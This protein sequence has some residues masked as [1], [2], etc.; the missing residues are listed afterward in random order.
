MSVAGSYTASELQ[1]ASPRVRG[2]KE[3]AVMTASH[4]TS[5][6]AGDNPRP[7]ACPVRGR[8]AEL[9]V[10]GSLVAEL[11]QGRGGVLVIE[12][13]PGIGKSRLL[14]ESRSLAHRAGIRT[15]FGQAFEYQQAVPF[16]SLFTAT[17]Y[18]DP[19]VGDEE[20]LRRL[21]SSADLRYWVVHDLNRAIRAAAGVTPLV[22]LLEDIHWADTSTLLA[23]RTLTA[24]PHVSPVLWVLTART[25]AGGPPVRDTVSELERQ[26]AMYLRLSAMSRSGV[27][28]MIEDAVRARADVS[29]LNL[30]DKAHGNPF[31]VT[32]LLGGLNEES[33]LCISR[34]CA[35]AAG[36]TLPRRLSVNMGQRLDALSNATT[37]VVQ[38]AAVLPDLFTVALLAQML[39][40]RPAAL[41][42][43]VEEAV[44]ADLL[45]EDGDHLRFR[46]DL[47]REATRQSLPPSLRRAVER[48]AATVMLEMGAAPAEVATQLARSADVGDQAA[49]TALREAAQ[50][51]AN[52]D[53]SGAA[54]LSK[55]AL[56]LLP[57][58]DTQ[59]GA[60]LAETVGLLN[61]SGRYQEAEEL[62]VAMLAQL[63]PEE[64]AQTR[65][66]TPN[67]ADALEK[68]IA[69]NRRALQL[70][71]I[72]DVTRARHL[73]WLACNDAVSGL[74]LDVSVI[75][76]ARAAAAVTGDPESGAICEISLAITDYVDGYA[77][78]GLTRLEKLDIRADGD[79]PSFT[80]AL[81]SIHQTTVLNFVGRA[82]EATDLM[83][84]GVEVSRR[85]GSEV[86][87]VLWASQGA[88]I[89]LA[90][91]RLSAA[92]VTL[93]AV[94]PRLWGAMSE[95]GMQRWL[96]LA[97]VAVRT[98]D[99]KLLQDIV[100]EARAANPAGLNLVQRGAAY[101]VALT[102]WDCGD[103]H[104][105]V[106]WMSCDTGQVLNP[107]WANSFDQLILT[108]RVA[109]AAGDAGLRA[110]ALRGVELLEHDSNEVPLFSAVSRH[111]LGIL[112]RDAAALVDA[113]AALRISRPLLSACAAEDAGAALAQTGSNAGAVDQFNY[114][115]DTYVELEA[116]ADARRVAGRLRCLGVVRRI[117][118]HPREKTG[119]DSLTAAELKVVNLIADGAT[120]PIV[121]ERLRLSPHTVK[122]HV[123]NAFAKLG[124]SCRAQLPGMVASLGTR[125]ENNP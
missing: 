85:E 15:L 3:C 12:G 100:V 77:L 115:F 40:R 98:G 5:P 31:L 44:R 56:D 7:I 39:E 72:S 68:R 82:Q 16:F 14:A 124:I 117:S 118:T 43:A 26:G 57:A 47:L 36:E 78:R 105:A 111:T 46:H 88:M 19:P 123:R 55:R 1:P 109:A 114:A 18:A 52:S 95:M 41:V 106:R 70:S 75:T 17:I 101:V 54:D 64:E 65:L 30:A 33:R 58:E 112:G 73:A 9:K 42:S 96:V 104:E 71:Q 53:K 110:R 84:R 103:V 45:V 80:S 37:E 91:G 6:S 69:E 102:A 29:L 92:R 125:S 79:D 51:M 4:Y 119:W 38:I 32:E 122:S 2:A 108:A 11:T 25:G 99:R 49:V 61:Q 121:A 28:D 83:A 59:R 8:A 21:G 81:A 27:I 50:S 87:S 74:P 60:L 35:V 93:E 24:P 67:A 48:Q 23:L 10:I 120:N 107:L 22:I 90:A 116:T 20:A 97:E 94:A 113:A 62:A 34:G 66:R 13:P 63:S 76:A 86:A 89:H